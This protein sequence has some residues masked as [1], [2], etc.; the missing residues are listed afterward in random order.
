MFDQ[1]IKTDRVKIA[2]IIAIIFHMIG[3][4]GI[5]FFQNNLIIQSTPLNL[6]LMVAL[7]WY[8]EEQKGKSFY[9][10]FII[11]FLA[12]ILVET[13]GVNTGLLFGDYGYGDV[14]GPKVLEVPVLIGLNWFMVMYC[15]GTGTRMLYEKIRTEKEMAEK[16][17]KK[18][19]LVFDSA[20]IA[21]FFDWL[22][23]PVAIK[24]DFWKWNGTGE[25][26]MFNYG[27]WFIISFILLFIFD[28]MKW[29]KNNLFAINLLLI[30]SMFFL[31]LRTFL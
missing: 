28:R 14:L 6:M 9:L 27:S 10:F 4:T 17:W 12:G 18:W 5:L 15:V 30:Q 24:L 16:S 26:P 21:V 2:T 23:E 25:I 22:M 11:S 1:V 19:A 29:K 8:T 20:L 7:I 3:L 13:I 31:I